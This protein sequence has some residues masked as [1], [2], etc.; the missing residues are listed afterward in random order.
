MNVGDWDASTSSLPV[1]NGSIGG[2]IV[3]LDAERD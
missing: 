2:Y 3:L 1:S